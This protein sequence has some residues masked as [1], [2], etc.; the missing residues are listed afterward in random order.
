MGGILRCI[1]NEYNLDQI[2]NEINRTDNISGFD[3]ILDMVKRNNNAY[4]DI[5]KK[6]DENNH[7]AENFLEKVDNKRSNTFCYNPTIN[8]L[9]I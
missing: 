9:K 1:K 3:E 2:E 6:A 8:K 5:D 7:Y 4:V